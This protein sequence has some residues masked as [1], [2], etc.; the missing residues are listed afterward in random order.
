MKI[1]H[2]LASHKGIECTRFE[3]TTWIFLMEWP[4]W[5]ILI[6]YICCPCGIQITFLAPWSPTR[7]S[8]TF[9]QT[10]QSYNNECFTPLIVPWAWRYDGGL[11]MTNILLIIHTAAVS[12]KLQD[13]H[14]QKKMW[15]SY[16]LLYNIW[17]SIK[18]GVKTQKF[19]TISLIGWVGWKKNC[20]NFSLLANANI[21]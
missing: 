10:S 6:I 4:S 11:T 15:T 17:Q 18:G 5:L 19:G 1:R 12:G 13:C 8:I 3:E 14:Q 21:P 2:L 7:S 20:P 9:G 16:C